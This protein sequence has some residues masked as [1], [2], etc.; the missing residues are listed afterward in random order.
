PFSGSPRQTS[1]VF[2]TAWLANG[3]APFRLGVHRWRYHGRPPK[4]L[5]QVLLIL[6]KRPRNDKPFI[7]G[8]MSGANLQWLQLNCRIITPGH[9]NHD[10]KRDEYLHLPTAIGRTSDACG[11]T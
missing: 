8:L 3:G 11:R 7:H 4:L 5:P 10:A 6:G 1:R 9:S 2:L